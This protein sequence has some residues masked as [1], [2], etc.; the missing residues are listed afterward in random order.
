MGG[1]GGI[2]P[3][4]DGLSRQ[5]VIRRKL[6][7]VTGQK[8]HLRIYSGAVGC[9]NA[10]ISGVKIKMTDRPDGMRLVRR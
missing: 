7:D 1:L 8:M 6:T 4:L 9:P 10:F 5:R 2:M 3:D